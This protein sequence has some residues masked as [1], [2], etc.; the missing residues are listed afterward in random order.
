[1]KSRGA[2][3]AWALLLLLALLLAAAPR[4]AGGL[5]LTT[6]D[7]RVALLRAA[8]LGV[9][10]KDAAWA[11][12]PFTCAVLVQRKCASLA[13]PPRVV[14]ACGAPTPAAPVDALNRTLHYFTCAAAPAAAAAAAAAPSAGSAAAGGGA[15]AWRGAP[16]GRR[17]AAAPLGGA[18]APARRASGVWDQPHQ[19][20]QQ[21]L[22][23]AW[24]QEPLPA[25]APPPLCADTAAAPLVCLETVPQVP[26]MG[27]A[28]VRVD[29]GRR[30][31]SSSQ[32]GSRCT[33]FLRHGTQAGGLGLGSD[34]PGLEAS[35]YLD[36]FPAADLDALYGHAQQAPR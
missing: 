16:V 7:D 35:P 6:T 13:A 31:A 8:A 30:L 2:P 20:Q 32:A 21:P 22:R 17:P 18:R 28:P 9:S 11:E 24:Q 34:A 4:P 27:R 10:V 12:G 36:A 26:P 33:C 29:L 23:A 19:Q 5:P 14:G 15:S 3:R 1:M 25:A